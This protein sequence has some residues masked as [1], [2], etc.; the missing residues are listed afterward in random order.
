MNN[1]R[2]KN[3]TIQSSS[4]KCDTFLEMLNSKLPPTCQKTDRR[5]FCSN[6]VFVGRNIQVVSG[7]INILGG[8]S[9]DYSE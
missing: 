7:G 5:A 6:D 9:K 8:G 1:R 4:I 3:K 2:K